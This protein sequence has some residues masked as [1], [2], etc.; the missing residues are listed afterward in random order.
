M[1]VSGM[2][3]TGMEPAGER[4]GR[5]AP[6]AEQDD[7]LRD[8]LK[9]HFHP[10]LGSDYWLARQD[11]LGWSVRDRVRTLDDLW[12]LGPTPPSRLR[13]HAVR[14]F[15]PRAFHRRLHR[16]VVGEAAGADGAPCAAAYRDD[17]FQEAFVA[18]FLRVAD[19][20]GF[21]G[22]ETWLWVG[23]SGPNLLGKAVRE[24]ARQTGAMDPFSVAFDPGWALRLAEGSLA[25]RRYL[26]HVVDQALDVLRRE[27]VGVLFLTPPM[28]EALARRLS[29]RQRE[30]IRG[31]CLGGPPVA[32]AV[33][34]RLRDAFPRAVHLSGCGDA[35][36]GVLV[37][38][39]DEPRG[40]AD[41]FPLGDRVQFHVAPWDDP[42]A[43]GTP[44]LL[45][46]GVRGRALFHRLDESGLL[47]GAPA[48]EEAERIAP[49]EGAL[50]LGGFGDGLRDPRP[51][52]RSGKGL[53]P[54]LD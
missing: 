50:A 3:A 14:R 9:L 15:I 31:V 20:A 29:D 54:S 28:P 27:S 39:D 21:P 34:N 16:F 12:L 51:P 35:L 10:H 6:A 22:G 46:R 25:R 1:E 30:A 24:L 49:S 33:R 40:A 43:D 32:A 53:R 41:Y 42:E 17:E 18:P 2:E 13:L 37:E 5:A 19:A 44:P 26:D 48:P 11:A 52:T 23:P 38:V 36:F 8:L 7:R 45:G 4:R 47:V